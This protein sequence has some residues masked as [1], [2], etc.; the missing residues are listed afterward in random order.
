MKKNTTATQSSMRLHHQQTTTQPKVSVMKIRTFVIGALTSLL[1]AWIGQPSAQAQLALTGTNYTEGFESISGGSLPS[2]WTS[3]YNA[4]A[5]AVGDVIPFTNGVA[6]WSGATIGLPYDMA[7]AH[8]IDPATTNLFTGSEDTATQAAATNRAPGMR[9]SSGTDGEVTWTLQIADTIGLADFTVSM[10]LLVLS[11]KSRTGTWTVDYAVGNAPTTFTPLGAMGDLPGNAFGATNSG[12]LAIPADANNQGDNLWIRLALLTDTAPSGTRDT[13]GIDDF[14][15]DYTGG[16]VNTDSPSITSQPQSSTN[17]AGSTAL[18][19][20]AA[21]GG[22]PLAY[23]WRKDGVGLSGANNANVSVADVV[24]ADA[25]DYDVVITNAYGAITSSVA[26]LTVIDD[27]GLTVAFASLT[28]MPGDAISLDADVAGTVPMSYQWLKDGVAISGASGVLS[29]INST[30]AYLLTTDATAADAGTYSVVVSNS[31]SVATGAVAS[32]TVVATPSTQLASWNYNSLVNDDNVN[33]GVDTPSI[34]SGTCF[35]TFDTTLWEYRG[36]ADADAA[37]LE[38][39]NDNSGFTWKGVLASFN[40]LSGVEVSVDTTGYRDI[41]VSW[42]ESNN[43]RSSRYMRFQYSTDGFTFIDA[44][45]FDFNGRNSWLLL[46]EA[47]YGIA[48][49]E[50]NPN[51]KFRVV[52][53]W[54]S[55]A[56]GSGGDNYVKNGG[57]S[58]SAANGVYILDMVSVWANPVGT[59][60][61]PI[62]ITNIV[63]AGGTVTVTFACEAWDTADEFTLEG[64]STVDG[65][66]SAVGGAIVSDVSPG[67]FQ[68][69]AAA[70][71]PIQF[72][73]VQH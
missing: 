62:D 44:T 36:G 37:D 3:R 21:E 24:T 38:E 31:M 42:N 17:S 49:V 10:D 9:L 4:S 19:I 33:T 68:A 34:G 47:L 23:Q 20:V 15:L 50:N 65:T 45:G 73:R 64:A 8:N 27:P 59:P 60:E 29:D 54:E 26:T 69:T 13:Y 16:V 5:S 72:Y 52:A 30:A 43:S 18:F 7:S 2:G 46:N 55:T 66:Y 56:T 40:K 67:V 35:I 63:V 57:S 1:V 70:S 58:F 48:G 61:S 39:T 12:S 32:V 14:V 51:F 53:E 28:N 22:P 71:S 25:G 41:L 6:T 11:S